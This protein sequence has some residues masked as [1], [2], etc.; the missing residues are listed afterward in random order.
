MAQQP[1]P[2]DQQFSA[3]VGRIFTDEKFAQ[4]LEQRP[5]QAL[6]EAGFNL[7]AEQVKAIQSGGLEARSLAT[8][9]ATAVAAVVRPV[10]S[11]LT[12]GTRPVVSVVVSTSAVAVT[13]RTK[14]DDRR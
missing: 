6:R 12:K 10:V 8:S 3:L 4:A 11:V 13:A 5:E 7:N 9:D 14:E 2:E 1:T